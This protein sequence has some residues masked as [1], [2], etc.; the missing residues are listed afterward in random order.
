MKKYIF[1]LMFIITLSAIIFLLK[2]DEEPAMVNS[3]DI[4][5]E[6]SINTEI[7]KK[8]N[9]K[10]ASS[11]IKNKTTEATT[12]HP[13]V[14]PVASENNNK[15]NEILTDIQK[16]NDVCEGAM[17][18]IFG[19]EDTN[20]NLSLYTEFEITEMFKKFNQISFSSQRMTE[21]MEEISQ[22]EIGLNEEMIS[23]ISNLKPCRM[24]QKINFLD[25]IRKF[26]NK[27]DNPQFKKGIVLELNN[28]FKNEVNNSSSVSN[29][30]MVLNVMESFS[31]EKILG[32]NEKFSKEL[33]QIIDQIEED[34]EDVLLAAEG[35]IEK[36]QQ[37]GENQISKEI[38]AKEIDLNSKYKKKILD[39]IKDYL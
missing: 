12:S 6:N 29:L 3:N 14:K 16:E 1:S 26:L 13:S 5:E 34:Y 19:P 21:L 30:T 23:Q 37:V 8:S 11:L 38:I 15:I 33:D 9:L 39:I 2:N 36:G 31:S 28:Y 18:E 7:D 20:L 32:V 22:D 17:N 4:S 27:T 35:S 10:F 24:F 25:E